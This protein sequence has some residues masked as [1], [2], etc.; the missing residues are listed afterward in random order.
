MLKTRAKILITTISLSPFFIRVKEIEIDH[1][2]LYPALQ[3]RILHQHDEFFLSEGTY[4]RG[5]HS[6]AG[7]SPFDFILHLNKLRIPI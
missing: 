2:D 1:S 3:K 5:F 6:A 7:G 4:T